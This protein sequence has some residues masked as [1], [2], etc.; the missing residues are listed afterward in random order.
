[1]TKNIPA[2]SVGRVKAGISNENKPFF[3]FLFL[4]CDDYLSMLTEPPELSEMR[5]TVLARQVMAA[6]EEA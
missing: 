5:E 3:L 1:M 6:P 4:V 2:F